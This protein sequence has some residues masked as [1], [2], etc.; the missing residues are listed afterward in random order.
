MSTKRR[1]VDAE[2]RGFQD[3]WTEKYF[4]IQHFGNPI[5]IIC[6]GS[7]A[8][9][10]EF[11]IKRHYE[12]K[13]PKFRE[14]SGQMRMDEVHKLKLSLEK[15]SSL[16]QKGNIESE[17][18]T[19]ASYEVSRLIAENMKPFTD[20]DFVKKCLIAVVDIVCPEK[21]TLFSNVSLSAR[22]VTRRI[23]E[24]SA[25][26]N[27]CLKDHF[28]NFDFFSIALDESTDITDTAQLA[29]FVRGVNK[30]FDIVE[31]FVQ[32]VPIKGSTTGADILKA[33]L[34]CTTDMQ[35]DLLKL[36]SV[37]TD[38]APAMVGKNKGAVA[39]LQ[40]HLEGLGIKHN[41]RKVHCIIHQEALCAKKSNLKDVMDVV[42]K[43]VN[44][45]L[46]R[47][48]NHR[49]FRQLLSE[50]ENQYGDLLYFCDVRWLSRGAM[51]ERVYAL[52]EDIAT[53]L[54]SKNLNATE[55]RDL[56]WLSRLAFLVD[57]TSHLNHLNL[58][59]QGKDQL[60]HDMWRHITAFEIKLRLWE[61]QL[62]KSNYAHFPTLE[63]TKPTNSN[64]F[65]NV[66]RD[67]RTDFF[68]RF[69]DLRSNT[70][71]F[72]L[73]GTPFDVEV[74]TVPDNFQMELIEMQCNDLLKSKFDAEGVSLL[75]FYKK[76]LLESGLY[77]NLTD[78]AKKMASM[79]GST[80]TCEQLFSKMTYTKNKLRSR[81]TDVHLENVLRLASSNST[82]S[83][84]LEK[85][86]STKQHQVSH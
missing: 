5:C 68:S 42:V 49:Q 70:V 36:V 41:V 78:H 25:D 83:P 28:K 23:E 40:K 46:S 65:V 6:H 15:Q 73:F 31:E 9:N 77:T 81:I 72:K 64:I 1:K 27:S 29:V 11:N 43:A 7:V 47:G 38:G 63:E 67:L 44:V 86:S 14:I 17:K 55:F 66:I 80:Y 13:H 24:M 85:L 10:K 32:L 18:N 19:R 82:I 35:L 75:E 71:D 3:T 79:F 61:C 16:F 21:K 37:T 26:M 22:T 45:I 30:T 69:A 52:R 20:G 56:K 60:I 76:Y 2:C 58:Q 59:L 54:E 62:E 84:D 53:F 50:A 74:N 4:F 34:Q 57:L 48:L 39:L 12:T 8:V 51:L 33:L